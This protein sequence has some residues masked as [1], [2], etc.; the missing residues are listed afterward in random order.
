MREFVVS[1]Y[2]D[3]CTLL[4]TRKKFVKKSVSSLWTENRTL[5]VLLLSRYR[6]FYFTST[7]IF[8]YAFSYYFLCVFI[9]FVML[10]DK[11]NF[12]IAF[13]SSINTF[14]LNAKTGTPALGLHDAHR[15][16]GN[17]KMIWRWT[18]KMFS[19]IIFNATCATK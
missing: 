1:A 7:F 2:F 10:F 4:V 17:H 15:I 5:T 19:T 13:L 3:Y 11:L 18:L 16:W 9:H 6:L 14:S 12:Y 8:T